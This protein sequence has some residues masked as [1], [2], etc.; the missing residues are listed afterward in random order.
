MV[1][2]FGESLAS[3][4]LLYVCNLCQIRAFFCKQ[5]YYTREL[6]SWVVFVFALVRAFGVFPPFLFFYSPFGETGCGAVWFIVF[7]FTDELVALPFEQASF[8]YRFY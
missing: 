7:L 2:G 4:N 5:S 8:V 1:S 3:S 6:Y